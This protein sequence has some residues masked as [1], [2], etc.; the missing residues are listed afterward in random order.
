MSAIVVENHTH[1]L[2]RLRGWMLGMGILLAVLGAVAIVYSVAVSIISIV[3]FGWLLIIVGI[4][5]TIHT[6]RHRKSGHFAVHLLDT[7]FAL[8]VGVML[9]LNSL[10]GLL[11]VTLLLAVYF[12]VAG[13][14]RI[15]VAVTT[16]GPGSG[17]T[18]LGGVITLL[19]GILV[20]LHWPMA[21]LWIIGLFI[22]INLLITGVSQIMLALALC[23]P[24]VEAA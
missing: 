19:L 6:L 20:W 5:G 23:R 2:H 1:E 12:I 17:W 22:G 16:R 4:I 15:G 18:L 3:F 14:Y 11:V 7:V 24:A 8:V 9:L 21:A 13:V 10:A